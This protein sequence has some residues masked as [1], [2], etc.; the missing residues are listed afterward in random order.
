MFL[1]LN[2][3]DSVIA[4]IIFVLIIGVIY[5]LSPEKRKGCFCKSCAHVWNSKEYSRKEGLP[6]FCP[7]CGSRDI[8]LPDLE[9]ENE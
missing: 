4:I 5:L 9:S 1:L 2:I 3:P 8:M 6:K 7:Q